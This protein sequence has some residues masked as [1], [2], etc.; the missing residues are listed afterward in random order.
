MQ[1][2]RTWAGTWPGPELNSTGPMVQSPPPSKSLSAHQGMMGRK[3]LMSAGFF[4][5]ISISGNVP[6]VRGRKAT[7][8][9]TATEEPQ[10]SRG[11]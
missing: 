8:T 11:I 10:N 5:A 6:H 3:C 1:H 9:A 2:G 7:A 4:N